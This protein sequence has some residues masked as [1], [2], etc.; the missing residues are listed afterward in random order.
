MATCLI[1]SINF[2]YYLVLR[3]RTQG[4]RLLNLA[5]GDS[6]WPQR[7][8]CFLPAQSGLIGLALSVAVT[9][10]FCCGPAKPAGR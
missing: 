7:W 8:A 2:A 3:V 5:I 4:F 9:D 1:F 10:S 6:S